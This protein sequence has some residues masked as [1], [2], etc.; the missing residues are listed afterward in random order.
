MLLQHKASALIFGLWAQSQTIWE[1]PK[2]DAYHQ[3]FKRK[4]LIIFKN[5]DE[6]LKYTGQYQRVQ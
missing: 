4:K 6:I 2:Y 5:T 1:R 3:L